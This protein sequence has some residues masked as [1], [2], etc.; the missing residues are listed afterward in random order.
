MW[1]GGCITSKA[2]PCPSQVPPLRGD[3]ALESEHR[4]S[5][6]GQGT[7]GVLEVLVL[8]AACVDVLEYVSDFEAVCDRP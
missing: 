7:S 8:H 3:D 6:E 1:L 4:H 5:K 2:G